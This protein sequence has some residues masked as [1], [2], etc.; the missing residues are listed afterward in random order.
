MPHRGVLTGSA[1]LPRSGDGFRWLRDDDHHH[2]LPRFVASIERAAGKVARERPGA[3]LTVG[4]LSAR[5]GGRLLPHSS[6][7]TGR[8]ADLLFYVQT[9]GGATVPSVDWVHIGA[10]GL[11]WDERDK[12]YVRLDVERQW[13]LVKALVEDEEARVQ[14]LFVSRPVENLLV[15]WARARGEPADT[16]VRAMDAMLQPAPPAQSHDD[17]LH[18]RTACDPAEIAAGCEP[19]GPERPW[20]MAADARRATEPQAEPMTELLEAILR[21]LDVTGSGVPSDAKA[22]R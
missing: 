16:I 10:D 11:G 3:T 6:H 8:D 7:R 18:L 2:G 12:R 5:T 1:E 20:I 9:L 21:P 4:D 15:E 13:L 17:H 14:W 19:T 22:S